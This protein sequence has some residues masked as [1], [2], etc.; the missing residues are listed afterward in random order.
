MARRSI[1]ATVSILVH[2]IVLVALASVDLWRP[3]SEWPRPHEAWAFTEP[4]AIHV[5]VQLPPE[6]RVKAAPSKASTAPTGPVRPSE[7][8]P[9]TPPTGVAPEGEHQEL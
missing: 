4:P 1:V 8:A 6:P 2:A 7:E 5:D 9:I 3:I